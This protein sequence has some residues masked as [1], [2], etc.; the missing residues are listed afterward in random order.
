MDIKTKYNN[1]DTVWV[2]KSKFNDVT[3]PACLGG[4]NLSGA[5]GKDYEC[6]NCYGNGSV[7]SV[8]RLPLAVE[9]GWITARVGINTDLITYSFHGFIDNK[10]E[11]N[12]YDTEA[13]CQ[14]ECDRLNSKPE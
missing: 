12:C 4:R 1:G 11:E 3:C 13:E 10:A 9:I 6:G 7:E 14:A 5:D 2:V 8:E